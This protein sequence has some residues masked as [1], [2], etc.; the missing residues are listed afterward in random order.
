MEDTGVA[1][2]ADESEELHRITLQNISDAVFITDDEGAFT[3]ICPN[4]D[5]IFGYG[6]D[7]VRRMGRIA[8]LLG[9]DLVDRGSLFRGG[10]LRNLEHE[11]VTKSGERRVLLVHVRGVAIRRGTTL[12]V[13]RDI[14]ERKASEDALRRNEERLALALEAAGMATWDWELRSGEVRWEWFPRTHA[15]GSRASSYQQALDT[16]HPDDRPRVARALEN[17]IERGAPFDAEFRVRHA[18]GSERRLLSKGKALFDS[19]G[20]AA[21]MLGVGLDVT[22]SRQSEEELRQQL[23]FEALVSELSARFAGLGD[24]DVIRGIEPSL[25]ALGEFL[26]VD[27]VAVWEIDADQQAFIVIGSWHADGVPP[28]PAPIPFASVPTSSAALLRGE[29]FTFTRLE[30]L[31]DCGDYAYLAGE[32][33]QSLLLI[34]VSIG[35]A[36]LGAVSFA[37]VGRQRAWPPPLVRRLHLVGE[38]VGAALARQRSAIATAEARTELFHVS[39]LSVAG[40]LTAAVAHEIR[41]PLTSIAA[42]AAAGLRMLQRRVHPDVEI[43]EILADIASDNRRAS[44][45]IS[46]LGELLRKRELEL[47]PLDINTVVTDVAHLI[48]A[49]AGQRDVTIGLTCSRDL[50]PVPGDRVYLQQV[51]LNLLLNAMEAMGDLPPARRQV[52]I[53]TVRQEARVEVSVSDRGRGLDAAVA[54]HIFEAFFT[55]RPDGTGLGLS[56]ARSIIEAHGGAIGAEGRRGGGA[57]FRFTLPALA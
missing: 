21:R 49:E 12:Y 20:R 53:R 2:R 51:L 10:E 4:V 54:P 41:Q 31:P 44:D 55:T 7:E 32:R 18:D 3:Y 45:V 48:R 1:A 27:R 14:T 57:T 34:P 5:V 17:A 52:T 39:R 6:V 23:Q 29:I 38:M 43:Q 36:W 22:S 9:G 30:D 56:I 50:P 40:E 26:S 11:I 42:N 46:R 8:A 25:G 33:I 13:C 47:R 28:V 37:M 16:V 15:E 24:A 19:A 35:G